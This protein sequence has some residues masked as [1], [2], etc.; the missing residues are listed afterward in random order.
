M[1]F[2]ASKKLL[3]SKF[4]KKD[5]I[6]K[7]GESLAFDAYLVD[8]GDNQGNNDPESNDQGEKSTDTEEIRKMHRQQS[9]HYTHVTARKSEWLVL[10]STRS[11]KKSKTYHDG[12]L[13]LE[14]F[15]SRGRQVVL[16]DLNKTPIERRF[17]KK[18]EVIRP[19]ESIYFDGHFVDVR[20][21]K[22]SHQCPMNSDEKGTGDNFGQR[23]QG[24]EQNG[25]LK[26]NPVVVKVEPNSKAYLAK[27][28]NSNSL[29][30]GSDVIESSR[31]VP[32]IKPLR[33]THQILSL[34]Q[35]RPAPKSKITGSGPTIASAHSHNSSENFRDRESIETVESSKG[36]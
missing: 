12:F 17:L 18:D 32:Q 36:K 23:K 13:Q 29:C 20:D 15:G 2:D 26:A 4:L 19:G 5:D 25:Y 22:E 34:L 3:D 8:I 33:D 35:K 27:E 10:Y 11:N 6:I 24:Y 21:P 16:C 1:L 30:S 14:I 31:I 9:C 28:A 7:P